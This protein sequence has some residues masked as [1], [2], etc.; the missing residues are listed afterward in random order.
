MIKG[1]KEMFQKNRVP[2]ESNTKYLTVGNILPEQ[3]TIIKHK[4]PWLLCAISLS[5][6]KCID[7]L[8]KI[9]K[10]ADSYKGEFLLAT[11]GSIEDIEEI[12]EFFKFNFEVISFGDELIVEG[13]FQETPTMCLIDENNKIIAMRVIEDIENPIKVLSILEGEVN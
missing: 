10:I 2:P 6:M 8:P 12:K 11:D 13:G 4:S 9:S 1:F 7:L 3:L 5:C